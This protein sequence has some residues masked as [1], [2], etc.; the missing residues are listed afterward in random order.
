[1][2]LEDDGQGQ[3][4]HT[5]GTCDAL[6]RHPLNGD[7]EK[8]GREILREILPSKII[9]SSS[10]SHRIRSA[11]AVGETAATSPPS[12]HQSPMPVFCLNDR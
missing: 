3:A 6:A 1:M 11:C 2:R 10:H 12:P 4:H 5:P 8:G 7:K 9:F